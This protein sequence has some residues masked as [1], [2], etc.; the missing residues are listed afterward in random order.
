MLKKLRRFFPYIKQYRQLSLVVVSIII[1]SALDISGKDTAAHWV[2]AISAIANV[3]PLIW[4]MV[5]DLRSGT[6]GVDI[7]AATAII[8]S[9]LFNEY[10]AAIVIVLMLTGGET[11]EDYAQTRAR[12]ELNALL[13][14]APKKA[15][16]MRG[17]KTVDIRVSQV[18]VNDK[19]IVK[20]GEI[21]S[22]DGIILE[23]TANFDESSLTG[24]SLPVAKKVGDE[25]LSGS[26]SVDGAVIV[27]TLRVAEDSQFEQII[28]LVRAAA[29]SKSPFVRLA[30]RYSIPF[31]LISF[32]IAIGA[33]MISGQ[34][35]RFLEVLVVATPCPLIFG[36]P[37]ALIS[38]MSR[39]A[40]HG[41]IIKTGSAMERL[42]DIKTIGFDKTGT[43]TRG[44]PEVDKVKIYGQF[45]PEEV[46][47][48][49][50]SLEQKSNHVLAKAIIDKATSAKAKIAK[51]KN[52][53]ELAGNGLRAHIHGRAI[54]VGRLGLIK[55][56]GIKTSRSFD[57][58]KIQQTAAFIAIDN[59]LA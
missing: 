57:A 38:G 36:A 18:R 23:G 51:A 34:P 9:V 45:T 27:R 11:L 46:L 37:I 15:H 8:S 16:V 52:V 19:L 17:R 41:I 21:V 50:A 13:G 44:R 43:L 49:A 24:E 58:T 54:V 22:V 28:K 14:S 12:T 55:E 7:L 25:V 47:S 4:D 3:I 42:A 30:D 1:A 6:Y 31:T 20:A 29:S 32:A 48:L 53:Q 40:K 2:L 35:I 26:I 59:Q 39:A 5:Q 10:W 33:W 56:Y